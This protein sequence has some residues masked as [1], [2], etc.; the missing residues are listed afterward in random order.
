MQ[1]VGTGQLDSDE[2]SFDLHILD[3]LLSNFYNMKIEGEA[4]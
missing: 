3:R 4:K 2:N 1:P